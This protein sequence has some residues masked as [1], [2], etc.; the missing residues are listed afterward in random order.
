MSWKLSKSFSVSFIYTVVVMLF[1]KGIDMFT[2]DVVS[3]NFFEK[4]PN[5]SFQA[6][7]SIQ[8]FILIPMAHGSWQKDHFHDS[9]SSFVHFSKLAPKAFSQ[10]IMYTAVYAASQ[11]NNY[12]YDVFDG[13]FIHCSKLGPKMFTRVF[14]YTVV[15]V[16]SRAF[17]F[18]FYVCLCILSTLP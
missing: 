4:W 11:S 14:I 6:F 5:S 1:L 15:H 2:I 18:R 10:F 8:L 7:S 17:C 3:Y 13:V 12:Y 9:C 16:D